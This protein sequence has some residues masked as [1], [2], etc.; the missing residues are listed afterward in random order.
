MG[1]SISATVRSV[2]M[3]DAD[4][5]ALDPDLIYLNHAAV[6]PWPRRTAAAVS[7]FAEE[8]ARGGSRNY[9]VWIETEKRLR[10]RLA[11][12]LNAPS[13]DDIALVKSTSEGLSLVAYGLDWE[14]G[15]NVV[16][17]RE[18]F[19]S[20]RIVWESLAN[21]GVGLRPVV[22]SG[23]DDPEAALLAAI[24]GRTR[25]LSISAVQYGDGLRLDLERLGHECRR[26]GVL[27]CVD[28]IQALGA[29]PFD[30]QAAQIDFAAADGH[31]WM[32]GPEG[33]AVFYV[34]AELRERLR[35]LQ[36]GWHMIEAAG[37]FER[38]DWEPA[39]G[40][41]RF[42]CGS[43]NMLGIHGLE[44]SLSL[45]EAVGIPEI[46]KS[47]TLKINK[48][49]E[50][51]EKID[52]IRV[53]T[54]ENPRRRAGIVTFRYR[55]ASPAALFAHLQDRGVQCAQRGGG[56]RLSPHFYTPTPQIEA[57]LRMIAAYPG[58]PR[59]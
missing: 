26:R 2:P 14:S 15:D 45:L 30:V 36:Y 7:A 56:I 22:L 54:P 17:A 46:D 44:A 39:H 16:S 24:D 55:D 8:N 12:L 50:E 11:R 57:V 31:K 18:E 19:P 38:L 13:E 20:N 35:L 34:R 41:R 48:L 9:P 5:F 49:C 21:R 23:A 53:L 52:N 29:V 3:D 47:L 59:H 10:G 4:E 33:L 6:A 58:E 27:F 43:P 37:D 42:E 40:A 25:L 51:L 32:L 1:P 28:A